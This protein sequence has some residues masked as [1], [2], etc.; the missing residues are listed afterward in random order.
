MHRLGSLLVPIKRYIGPFRM[1][2]RYIGPFW[3]RINATCLIGARWSECA[4]THAHARMCI[5]ACAR[6]GGDG[7]RHLA[8]AKSRHYAAPQ[9]QSNR[10][11]AI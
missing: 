4:L 7:A 6:G 10:P 5:G 11:P 1:H 3:R 2:P 9:R 8:A